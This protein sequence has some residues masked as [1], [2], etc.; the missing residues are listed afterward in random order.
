MM[1]QQF[2]V[3]VDCFYRDTCSII[4][5]P[6]TQCW[7]GAENI[8]C[9]RQAMQLDEHAEGLRKLAA[10]RRGNA[11]NFIARGSVSGVPQA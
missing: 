5:L 11:M 10:L 1:L 4:S 9:P 6:E 7:V 2:D 3:K 8:V